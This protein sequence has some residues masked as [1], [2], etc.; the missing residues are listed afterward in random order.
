[1]ADASFFGQT[2]QTFCLPQG[3]FFTPPDAGDKKLDFYIGVQEF[4]AGRL[5]MRF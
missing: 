5:R 4:S 2:K 3:H 1:M